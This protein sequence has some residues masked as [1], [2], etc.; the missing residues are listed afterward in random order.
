MSFEPLIMFQASAGSGKTYQLVRRY[1]SLLA[2]GAR[3]DGILATTF[4]RKAA[5]EIFQRIVSLLIECAEDET[6][7]QS[8]ASFIEVPT[9][10]SVKAGE[11][12]TT[13]L[14][15]ISSLPIETLD[16]FAQKFARLFSS[17]IE[18]PD[19]WD[20]P[21][22]YHM[23]QLEQM[24]LQDVLQKK[25][26]EER[27]ELLY[28]ITTADASRSVFNRIFQKL[29]RLTDLS[30]H[31][32]V[33]AWDW[34]FDELE[35]KFFTSSAT[36]VKEIVDSFDRLPDVLRLNG[37]PD[38]RWKKMLTKSKSALKEE[39]WSEFIKSGLAK[40]LLEGKT[41][42]S[43]T[44]I[45]KDWEEAFREALSFVSKRMAEDMLKDSRF[46]GS[47]LESYQAALLAEKSRSRCYGFSDIKILLANTV[48]SLDMLHIAY[49][50]DRRISHVLID[51]YQDTTRSEWHVLSKLTDEIASS[52]DNERSALIV[53][54]P[55]QGIYGW[56][57]GV[58]TL[59]R[60]VKE[61]YP[62]M[63]SVD[64]KESYRSSPIVISFLNK[65]F[66][67]LEECSLFDEHRSVVKDWLGAY[68]AHHAARNDIPGYISLETI[69]EEESAGSSS[70]YIA[71]RVN[72]L[73][74]QNSSLEIAILVRK[75]KEILPFVRACESLGLQVS[76]EGG[77]ALTDSVIVVACLHL[78]QIVMYRGDTRSRYHIQQTPIAEWLVNR[79]GD[80]DGGLD[81]LTAEIA[82]RGLASV[83]QDV[84]TACIKIST[85]RDVTRC[86]QLMRLALAHDNKSYSQIGD[87]IRYVRAE[88]VQDEG[89]GIV[90]VMTIHKSKGL[91]FDAVFLPEL[92]YAMD[93]A[94]DRDFLKYERL[95]GEIEKLLPYVKKE[96]RQLFGRIEKMYNAVIRNQ[97][98]EELS[99]LYVALSR[100]KYALYLYAQE[101]GKGVKL[102][103]ANILIKE[104]LN[105]GESTYEDGNSQWAN[106]IHVQEESSEL[107]SV[108]YVVRQKSQEGTLRK[109]FLQKKRPSQSNNYLVIRKNSRAQLR[110]TL[111]HRL[112]EKIDWYPNR[113][114]QPSFLKDLL[115]SCV[116]GIDPTTESLSDEIV[117]ILQTE[118]VAHCFQSSRYGANPSQL[119]LY[120]ELPFSF[121]EQEMN[122]EQYVVSGVI[123]RLVVNEDGVAE[124]LEFKTGYVSS[125]SN[126]LENQFSEQL[127]LY[128]RAVLAIFPKVVTELRTTVCFIDR[129]ELIS[130]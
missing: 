28:T 4:S 105:G 82:E 45:R 113:E 70:E 65:L 114:E 129:G 109:K 49:R 98:T 112:I 117:S 80:F 23:Q 54:D 41:E 123:D 67:D 75:N 93:T 63:R 89:A 8:V 88:R 76:A 91:E 116:A 66:T 31:V 29:T 34:S 101:T 2:R 56:R 106:H 1:V 30:L 85:P 7:A 22:Q 20:I 69:G 92:T 97:L 128:R 47:F 44:E 103:P 43:G 72:E 58:A 104:F 99:V 38:L 95:S 53:G 15:Q 73:L 10:D 119:K 6:A 71:D 78:L 42:F 25:T 55:K 37:A 90:R 5:D 84:I 77:S 40:S 60:E 83:L 3:P 100:A 126:M 127:A 121:I 17:E 68:S 12:L 102:T 48:S 32:P 35:P 33:E 74:Q 24:V 115:M 26:P 46:V 16:S 110:G 79:Y 52:P 111:I 120:R 27:R 18:L 57:G 62:H 81:S 21:S 50:L 13:L 118:V 87:F 86:E 64:L 124:I 130:S 107:N 61:S 11:L 59:F 9:F 14:E 96:E 108:R 19:T 51:E 122:S 36:N 125:E 39:A 94:Q